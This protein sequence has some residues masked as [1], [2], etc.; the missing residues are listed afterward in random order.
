MPSPNYPIAS[1]LL[2]A[3]A[4]CT[5]A[6]K[7]RNAASAKDD[8]AEGDESAAP[9]TGV[10]RT[11][12]GLIFT[13]TPANPPCSLPSPDYWGLSANAKRNSLLRLRDES[14]EAGG[15][16]IDSNLNSAALK[17]LFTA[18]VPPNPIIGA[19][20]DFVCSR[21]GAKMMLHT[22][23][24]VCDVIPP[25][26][27][28]GKVP[29]RVHALGSVA[30][31]NFVVINKDSPFTGL[32]SY[33]DGKRLPI[34]VRFSLANPVW[35]TKHEFAGIQPH[36]LHEVSPLEFIPGIGIKFFF[37]NK[38]SEDLVAMESLAGQYKSDGTNDRR[39]FLHDFTTNFTAHSPLDASEDAVKKRYD[40][41]PD[42]NAVMKVVGQRFQEA[43]NILGH[44]DARPFWRSTTN[45]VAFNPDGSPAQNMTWP[46]ELIFRATAEAKEVDASPWSDFRLALGTLSAQTKV[47][48]V[49]G[50]NSEGEVYIGEVTLEDTPKPSSWGDRSLFFRHSV[51][52]RPAGAMGRGALATD[53][54]LPAACP[55]DSEQAGAPQTGQNAP[56][57]WSND[58]KCENNASQQDCLNGNDGN[59]LQCRWYGNRCAAPWSSCPS[60]TN[61]DECR[62]ISICDWD[63]SRGYCR[64]IKHAR[65]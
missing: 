12:A 59:G 2:L 51:G 9:K 61:K 6:C 46:N 35:T 32:L 45:L 25:N 43:L 29:K 36:H 10:V 58:D 27:D 52:A 44:T 62:G 31:A 21:D 65:N 40:K 47:F 30:S 42:N 48:D 33:Q 1:V 4:L 63:N 23:Q 41:D 50:T 7:T 60:Y 54:P 55:T 22:F 19:T 39:Y 16:T 11:A 34:L 5:N 53:F 28:E 38:P 49:Y 8:L 3:S 64:T 56:D 17:P 13:E 24:R 14:F 57:Y 20:F 15:G 18:A 26:E 37:G